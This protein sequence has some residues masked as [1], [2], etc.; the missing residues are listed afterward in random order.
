MD[1]STC[2]NCDLP[3]EFRKN[4]FKRTL[5][6]KLGIPLIKITDILDKKVTIPCTSKQFLCNSCA[7]LTVKIY[8]NAKKNP[9]NKGKTAKLLDYNT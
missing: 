8:K 6:T 7:S 2:I 3:F 5:I 1:G 4:G 9:Q